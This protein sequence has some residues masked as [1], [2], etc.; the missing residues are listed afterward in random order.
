MRSKRL[1]ERTRVTP[2]Q[3]SMRSFRKVPG[4]ALRG[5]AEQEIGAKE[6][7]QL[8]PFWMWQMSEVLFDTS[9]GKTGASQS[10]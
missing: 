9:F 6:G 8:E 10:F 5:R 1:E 2:S 4:M 3:Q 7:K